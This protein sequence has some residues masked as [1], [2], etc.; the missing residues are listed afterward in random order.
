LSTVCDKNLFVYKNIFTKS[1]KY[2]KVLNPA[3][4]FFSVITYLYK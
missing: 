2:V 4:S 1:S 3:S